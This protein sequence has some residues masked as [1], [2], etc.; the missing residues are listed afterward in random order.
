MPK[1]TSDSL[2]PTSDDEVNL[3]D[4][5][6]TYTFDER[7]EARDVVSCV[8]GGIDINLGLAVEES[9]LALL[10]GRCRQG[11]AVVASHA[12][13]FDHGARL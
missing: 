9:V 11:V 12:L 2:P 10:V 8:G 7:Y 3:A 6:E 13:Y 4:A 5:M 1:D